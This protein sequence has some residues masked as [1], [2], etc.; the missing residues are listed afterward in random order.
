MNL[1]EAKAI[2]R[3][4]LIYKGSSI[5]PF[6]AQVKDFIIVPSGKKEFDL[7]FKT[8]IDTRISFELALKP[9]AENVTILVYFDSP[10]AKDGTRYCHYDQFLAEK[11]ITL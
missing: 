9:Y 4:L 11:N 2:V 6:L 8:I 5:V 10:I 1:I 7:M 3:K